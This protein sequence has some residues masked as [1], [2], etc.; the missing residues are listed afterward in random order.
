[1]QTCFACRAGQGILDSAKSTPGVFAIPP[2]GMAAQ[3]VCG[4]ALLHR[5]PAA[6]GTCARPVLARC[7]SHEQRC[8][9]R[10]LDSLSIGQPASRGAGVNHMELD[11][12]AASQQARDLP[13]C[14]ST[15]GTEPDGTRH[16]LLQLSRRSCGLALGASL[17]ALQAGPAHAVLTAPPG[18]YYPRCLLYVLPVSFRLPTAGTAART[19]A[20]LPCCLLC[21][22]CCLSPLAVALFGVTSNLACHTGSRCW[23]LPLS[24]PSVHHVPCSCAACRFCCRF[25]LPPGRR[26]IV[27]EARP[28]AGSRLHQ[29]R[30]DGY[31]FFYPDTWSPVTVRLRGA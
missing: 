31:Y 21:S 30:L 25:L 9:H 2:A 4:G 26:M 27:T 16:T 11:S 14:V 10:E 3:C 19:C 7:Q 17:L 13:L 29:D 5:R 18:A 28:G 20:C 24:L 23:C 22:C 6:F 1:M 8:S 12:A 15:C